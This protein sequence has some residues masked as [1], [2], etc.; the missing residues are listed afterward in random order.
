MSLCVNVH[1]SKVRECPS[2]TSPHAHVHT[3]TRTIPADSDTSGAH[4]QKLHVVQKPLEVVKMVRREHAEK[5]GIVVQTRAEHPL[6]HGA[7]V[8]QDEIEEAEGDLSNLGHIPKEEDDY[9]ERGELG[10]HEL[11]VP[12]AGAEGQH[13]EVH[14]KE[15]EGVHGADIIEHV[16]LFVGVSECVSGVCE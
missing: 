1:M 11:G 12:V 2:S 16:L 3:L 6:V 10:V 15:P 14:H 8:A 9:K 4:G 5:G 7:L 13:E